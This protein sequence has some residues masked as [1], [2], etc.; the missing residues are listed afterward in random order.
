MA[1]LYPPYI[2]G[3]LP[4]FVGTTIKVPF[5]MN[6]TVSWSDINGFKL[7]IKN[8]QTNKTLATVTA[9]A[10]EAVDDVISF[11][12]SGNSGISSGQFYKT[13]L[14]YISEERET[15]YY[16]TVGI[17]KKTLKPTVKII[18]KNGKSLSTINPQL[19]KRVYVGQYINDDIGE[20]VYTY[21]FDVYDYNGKLFTT[22]GDLLHNHEN[23][24][25]SDETHDEFILNKTLEDNKIYKIQYTV[26]TVNGY[27]ASSPQYRILQRTTIEPT[28]NVG[29]GAEVNEEDG[30]IRI[31]FAPLNNTEEAKKS[32]DSAA[33][34]TFFILRAS[35]E[36]NFQTW[37]TISN[38]SLEGQLPRHW[39][40]NDYTVQAGVI[41]V[42]ALQQYNKTNQLYSTKRYSIPKEARFEHT[43]LFD[44]ERQLKIKFNPKISSYKRTVLEAKQDTLGG[45][46]PYFYRNGYTDYKEFPISGLISY[47]SDENELFL[48]DEE[49]GLHGE[50]EFVKEHLNWQG[51]EVTNRTQR[52]N[53][54]VKEDN[55]IRTTNLTNYNIT[56]ERI[57]KNK[58]LEFLTNGKPKLFKSATEGN[59]IVRLMNTSLTP[60]D[61]LGRMLH[62][63][64]CTAY[65]V[66]DLNFETLNSYGFIHTSDPKI[67]QIRIATVLLNDFK[68]STEYD[69]RNLSEK[70]NKYSA[71]FIE[72]K[73]MWPGDKVYIDG[74]PYVIGATGAY[75]LQLK[76]KMFTKIQIDKNHSGNGSI[77]YGYYSTDFDAFSLYKDIRM[78]DMPIVQIFGEGYTKI[79]NE[80]LNKI[81]YIGNIIEQFQ[82]IKYILSNFYFLRFSKKQLLKASEY[83]EISDELKKFYIY[84]IPEDEE[85]NINDASKK[86]D[87]DSYKI[88][89]KQKVKE[90]DG[91]DSVYTE[92]DIADTD[93][94]QLFSHNN[95]EELYIGNGIIAELSFSRREIIYTLEET[96]K[97]VSSAKNDYTK[98]LKL[99]NKNPNGEYKNQQDEPVSYKSQLEQT[100][101]KFIETLESAIDSKKKGEE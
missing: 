61:Q 30:Y 8:I 68:N 89:I 95:I 14:A 50:K 29:I 4:A 87:N 7:K 13:Q 66:D 34:G 20:K 71:A 69:K 43:Y 39:Y 100:Y 10:S 93:G 32:M 80:D 90:A 35:S 85:D 72:C 3:T 38:F 98:A 1:I 84:Y 31:G 91:F 36:D 52:K 28:I 65:E 55:R 45:K 60:N 74:V 46:Y 22:S 82:D 6:K 19:D 37:N 24:S 27:V 42:Y 76:N 2:E 47:L 63:F 51:Q 33:T 97:K 5:M 48:T 96:N 11:D 75:S 99:Y 49:L 77:T 57:F 53:S 26:T 12:L 18:D 81:K 86:F 23:N 83:N 79:D 59:A 101:I 92:I 64:N 41:Y 25:K 70:L 94:Y 62:T 78:V 17:V 9:N 88:I 21:R 58:V 56:I 15:G 73:D 44:G 16:S 40:W 54:T 67:K